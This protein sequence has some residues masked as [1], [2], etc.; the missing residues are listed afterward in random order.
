MAATTENLLFIIVVVQFSICS[1][2]ITLHEQSTL[3]WKIIVVAY[4]RFIAN[5][6]AVL[7]A[8]I[9]AFI[10]NLYQI[11]V[12]WIFFKIPFFNQHRIWTL[13]RASSLISVWIY[14]LVTVFQL[15]KTNQNDFEI[16]WCNYRTES[17]NCAA[18]FII[19][20]SLQS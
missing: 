13:A 20:T 15:T 6:V 8:S 10:H 12:L 3:I 1:A 16:I 18:G 17:F 2:H 14:C 7:I 4:T 19:W 5:Y 9:K 11:G